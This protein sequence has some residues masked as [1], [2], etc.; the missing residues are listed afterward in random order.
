LLPSSRRRKRRK[1]RGPPGGKG[2]RFLA[3]GNAERG[4]ERRLSSLSSLSRGGGKK[5]RRSLSFCCKEKAASVG[6]EKRVS[7]VCPFVRKREK[8]S[9]V[10]LV[11]PRAAL[12]TKNAGGRRL[13]LP[14]FPGE[15]KGRKD[16]DRGLGGERRVLRAAR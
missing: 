13:L 15:R 9:S 6:K 2:E 4:G 11:H 14:S 7:L 8:R 1:G 16:A 3:G 10:Y 12:R 5:E